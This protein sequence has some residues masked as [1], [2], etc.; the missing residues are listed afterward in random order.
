MNEW[1]PQTPLMTTYNW[2]RK[3]CVGFMSIEKVRS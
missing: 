2:G 1:M 3:G